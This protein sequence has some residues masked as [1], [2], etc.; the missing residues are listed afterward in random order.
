MLRSGVNN[1]IYF[2]Q[3]FERIIITVTFVSNDF[4][5][6]PMKDDA[7]EKKQTDNSSR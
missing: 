4:Y 5:T 2:T 3:E 6:S 1:R 7:D